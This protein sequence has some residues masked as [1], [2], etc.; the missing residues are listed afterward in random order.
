MNDEAKDEAAVQS[1]SG[2][3]LA[4]SESRRRAVPEAPS[5][6]EVASA[7]ESWKEDV[8]PASGKA[9]DLAADLE[10]RE[11]EASIAARASADEPAPSVEMSR[12]QD[13]AA[14]DSVAPTS[15][16]KGEEGIGGGEAGSG[17]DAHAASPEQGA[18]AKRRRAGAVVKENIMPRVERMRDEA[19]V[20]LEETPDD[21]G[22]RFVA[23]A[24]ALFLLF[25]LLLFLSTVLK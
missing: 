5:R 11:A 18:Q 25:L 7:F 14:P 19:L 4:A 24:V 2:G 23:A 16:H 3:G 13:G 17:S 8:L 12:E 15:R 20:A 6:R 1:P 10:V 22:L 21:A 9:A